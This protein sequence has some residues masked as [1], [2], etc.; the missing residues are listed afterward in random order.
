M[1]QIFVV[2]DY[3]NKFFE[4]Y[5]HN[6]RFLGYDYTQRRVIKGNE[7]KDIMEEMGEHGNCCTSEISLMTAGVGKSIYRR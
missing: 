3:G 2:D 6:G 1:N 4:L 7:L 5:E